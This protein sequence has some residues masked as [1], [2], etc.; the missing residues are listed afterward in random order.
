[1]K[2]LGLPAPDGIELWMLEGTGTESERSV[3]HGLL[4]DDERSRASDF[5]VEHAR[6]SFVVS[7]GVLRTILGDALA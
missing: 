6:D 3:L 1:M 5:K 2:P 4:S 7:R